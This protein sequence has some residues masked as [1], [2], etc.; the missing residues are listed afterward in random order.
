MIAGRMV[1]R[2]GIEFPLYL[3]VITTRD[4]EANKKA[5]NVWRYRMSARVTLETDRTQI[6]RSPRRARAIMPTFHAR[7]APRSALPGYTSIAAK[8]YP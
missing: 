5:N 2:G 3:I 4:L 6:S 1:P 8:D 7:V